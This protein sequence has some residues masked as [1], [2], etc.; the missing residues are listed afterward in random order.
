MEPDGRA[1]LLT[2]GPLTLDLRTRQVR[3]KEK[4]V[5]L[6]PVEFDLLHYLATHPREVFSSKQ[7]M[8]Q[9]W[10]DHSEVISTGPVRWHIK[11]LRAKIE[12]D[13]DH[14]IYI[15]TVPHHGYSLD[16]L[17]EHMAPL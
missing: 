14:P 6:T 7:L 13:P 11:N 10:N 1:P 12:S 15:R 9:V 2:V 4:A 8:K 17:D 16:L 5:K 3:V